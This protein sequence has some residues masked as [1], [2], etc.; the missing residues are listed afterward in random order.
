ML[1]ADVDAA[2]AAVLDGG[3]G[4]RRAALQFYARHPA[5]HPFLAECNGTVVGTAVAIDHGRVGWVGLVFVAPGLRG[6]GL[7]GVLTRAVIERLH[8][9]GCRSV[10]LA[11]TDLGRPVYDR[12]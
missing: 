8:Q 9:R 5:T 1:P 6:Q 12:L 4:D 11:A 2:V 10:L 3:W 7:G